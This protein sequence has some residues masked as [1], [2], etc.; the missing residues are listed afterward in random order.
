MNDLQLLQH[1]KNIYNECAEALKDLKNNGKEDNYM[2]GL[3][4]LQGMKLLIDASTTLIM[5]GIEK[6][7]EDYE[8]NNKDV[9]YN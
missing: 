1:L 5:E 9:L 3:A 7:Y 2:H 4:M 8:K 6:E